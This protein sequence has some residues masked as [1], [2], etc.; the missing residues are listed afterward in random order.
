ML[1]AAALRES[2]LEGLHCSFAI[3][4]FPNGVIVL[5][6]TG[7]DIGEF[8]DRP[9]LE[10]AE[11]VRDAEP[12]QLYIDARDVR[13]ASMNVSSA[14]AEWLGTHRIQFA[15]ISMLTGTRYVEITADFVRR[16]AALESKMRIYT[17][18]EIFET[19]LACSLATTTG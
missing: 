9:M 2:E 6:I 3:R 5:T 19:M 14:W 10:L 16:F 1:T 8:G 11:F 12:V 17:E 4:R 13:G 7:T 15:G 18:P